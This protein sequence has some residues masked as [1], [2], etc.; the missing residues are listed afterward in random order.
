MNKSLA[1]VFG[2]IAIVLIAATT[3]VYADRLGATQSN[4]SNS[5]EMSEEQCEAMMESMHGT[6]HE[7][8][9]GNSHHNATSPG[10]ENGMDKGMMKG[11][12]CH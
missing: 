12:G 7:P 11:G 9:M 8:M 2:I 3:V 10:N 6:N 1:A 4:N 5:H